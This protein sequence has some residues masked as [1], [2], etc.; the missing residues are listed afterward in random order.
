MSR[1]LLLAVTLTC[2]VGSTNEADV[3]PRDLLSA[4]LESTN[5]AVA[6]ATPT[7]DYAEA[8][9]LSLMFYY[10]QR[11]GK[12][13]ANNPIPWRKDSAL[14]DCVVGGWYDAGDHVKFG[15][16]MAGALTIL[17]WGAERFKDGYGAAGQLDAMYDTAK[18]GLDYLVN[19]WNP[20]TQE[21]V[22]QVGDGDVDHQFWGRPEEMTMQRPCGKI[23]PGKPG[24]DVA[25]ESAAALAAGSL[26]FKEKG[27]FAYASQLLQTAESIY[28]FAKANRGRF[29]DNPTGVLN[30]WYYG[31]N[32]D[33]DEMCEAGV[34]LY[35]ATGEHQ[36]LT[37]AEHEH[38]ATLPDEYSWNDKR[39]ACQ[40]LLF[41]ETQG[42]DYKAEVKAFLSS[43]KP[44][45]T[46]IY[47]PCGIAWGNATYWGSARH[48]SNVAFA[49]LVAAEDGINAVN[50][51][52]WA[53]E[54]INYLLGD[55][56][57]DGGCFSYEI[58]YGNKYPLQPHHRAASCPD[59][60]APCSQ[61]NLDANT[62]SPQVLYGGLVGGPIYNDG[63]NDT[64]QDYVHNEVA[65]DYNSGFQSALAGLSQLVSRHQFPATN[66]KCP[67]QERVTGSH[68]PIIG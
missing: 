52:Q 33:K 63:Y 25:G 37:D 22:I 11:S 49:A 5:R 9:R 32:D 53:A 66:N 29:S 64:R 7:K 54:Q 42:D 59:L 47:S 30:Q 38:E 45:G 31:S 43:W 13:P 4:S 10:A 28:A 1:T 26:V 39:A 67:C 14:N 17:L 51:R 21:L 48:V 46:K 50:N 60:P 23:G 58:G 62:P 19:S 3:S 34:W 12:L 18:W 15:F 24:S 6:A 55:N 35:K 27:D 56:P 8:I 36:Y 20:F 65:L 2:L 44:G 16:P 68:S 41:E 61:S 40:L 57:H